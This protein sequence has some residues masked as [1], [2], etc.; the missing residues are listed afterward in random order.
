MD[1]GWSQ[2]VKIWFVVV[3]YVQ[4]NRGSLD[5]WSVDANT[6]LETGCNAK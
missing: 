6:V 1:Y 2:V 4:D 5:A 3:R